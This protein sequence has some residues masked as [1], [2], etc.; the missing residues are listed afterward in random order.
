[1]TFVGPS[2]RKNQFLLETLQAGLLHQRSKWR[3]NFEN[4]KVD[5]LVVLIDETVCRSKWEMGIVQ[6][7]HQ[8]GPHVRKA[9]IRRSNGKIELRDQRHVVK[10]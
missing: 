8:T 10:L 2:S 3:K 4:L 6:K 9:E 1:M 7:I 5:N